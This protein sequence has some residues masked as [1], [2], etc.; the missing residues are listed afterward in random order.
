VGNQSLCAGLRQVR[1]GDP[2]VAVLAHGLQCVAHLHAQFRMGAD[3]KDPKW[4][5]GNQGRHEKLQEYPKVLKENIA[6]FTVRRK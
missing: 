2:V 3:E 5:T 1:L 4:L 6:Q